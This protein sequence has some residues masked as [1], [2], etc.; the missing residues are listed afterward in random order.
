MPTQLKVSITKGII[1]RCK[2]CGSENTEH[3]IG[4]NC[5][6]AFA[7]IDIFPNI[8]V[9]GYSI[10]PFGIDNEKEKDIKIPLPPIAQQFI[11]LFDGF[12][13]TPKLRLMLPEFEFIIDIPDEVI[14]EINIDELRIL[15]EDGKKKQLFA[16]GETLLA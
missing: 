7:L 4:K 13:L 2:N 15:A 3:L 9:S 10:L 6:I 8:Y 14:D 1:A 5:A 12:S 11:K 16:A